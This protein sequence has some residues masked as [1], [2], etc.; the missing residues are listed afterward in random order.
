MQACAKVLR[1]KALF[2]S[3]VKYRNFE[4]NKKIHLMKRF[5]IL[6]SIIVLFELLLVFLLELLLLELTLVLGK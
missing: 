5:A 2:G 1:K 6:C 3:S 4:S